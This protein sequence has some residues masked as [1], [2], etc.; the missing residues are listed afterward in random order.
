MDRRRS[1]SVAV[2]HVVAERQIACAPEVAFDLMAD[3]RNEPGWNSQVSRT[4]LKSGESIAA[5]S[6]FVIVN[7]GEAFDATIS[8]HD[9]GGSSSTPAGRSNSSSGMRSRRATAVPT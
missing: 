1:S 9:R 7:R 3:V 2:M 6:P 5:V 4:E 8:T